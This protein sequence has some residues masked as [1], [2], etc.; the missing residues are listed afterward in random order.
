MVKVKLSLRSKPN[1]N[2]K[3]GDADRGRTPLDLDW[4]Q[5]DTPLEITFSEA[6]KKPV[7]QKIVPDHAQT[8][9]VVLSSAAK[10]GKASKPGKQPEKE[11][12]LLPS[13]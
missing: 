9:E 7:T 10:A 1:A 5:S 8:V 13:D 6:G 12:F 11:G 2:V 3:I 4:E